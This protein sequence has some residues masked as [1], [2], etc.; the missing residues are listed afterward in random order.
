MGLY[1]DNGNYYNEAT[2]SLS[3]PALPLCAFIVC[4]SLLL[5]LLKFWVV[6]KE[7]NFSC[8]TGYMKQIKGFPNIVALSKFLNSNPNLWLPVPQR[9]PGMNPAITKYATRRVWGSGLGFGRG[10]IGVPEGV[11]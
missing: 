1:R 11:L 10:S 7:L 4:L 6:V 3:S 9:N 5:L 2:R 8:H